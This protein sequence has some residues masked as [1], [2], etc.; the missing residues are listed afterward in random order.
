MERVCRQ[1][2]SNLTKMA[3]SCPKGQKTLWEKEILLVTSNFSFS[4][5]VFKRL[6]SQE[7][8]KVSL[9]G[10]GLN[11]E[12][13][14]YMYLGQLCSRSFGLGV[15][16]FTKS[17]NN[18]LY[19]HRENWFLGE[20]LIAWGKILFLG[21]ICWGEDADNRH[22]FLVKKKNPV[23]KPLRLLWSRKYCGR[24]RKCCLQAF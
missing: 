6:V 21:K 20:N 18:T 16:L 17:R 23:L 12:N 22:H 19:Q 10:N 3:E 9:Y 8:Q 11:N 7:R 15:G 14:R 13:V 2:L 5:S 4:H 1:T 24:R